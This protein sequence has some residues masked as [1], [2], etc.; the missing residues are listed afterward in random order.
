M[1]TARTNMDFGSGISGIPNH[2]SVNIQNWKPQSK[3]F[4]QVEIPINI[5][6]DLPDRINHVSMWSL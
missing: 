6:D 1:A 3:R 4:Y 2:L 5:L